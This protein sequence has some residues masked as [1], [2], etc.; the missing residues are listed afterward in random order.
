M[1]EEEVKVKDDITIINPKEGFY[2]WR[3][4]EGKTFRRSAFFVDRHAHNV[5]KYTGMNLSGICPFDRRAVYRCLNSIFRK[6]GLT[7]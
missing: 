2:Q 5:L 1:S 6:A 7:R 3:E 4:R